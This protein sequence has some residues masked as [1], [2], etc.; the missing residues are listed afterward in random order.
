MDKELKTGELKDYLN[1]D[2]NADMMR[3]D[4]HE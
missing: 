2:L 1:L 4:L 3:R